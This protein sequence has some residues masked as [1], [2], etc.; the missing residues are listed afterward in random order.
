MGIGRAFS[1]ILPERAGLLVKNWVSG[2][3]GW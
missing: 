1:P 3:A 2:F